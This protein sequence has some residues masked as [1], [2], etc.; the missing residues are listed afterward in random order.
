MLNTP[1][2]SVGDAPPDKGKIG[3]LNALTYPAM[4]PWAIYDLVEFRLTPIVA[5]KFLK[6]QVT[7][8]VFGW[9]EDGSATTAMRF[10]IKGSEVG[11]KVSV[12]GGW[13]NIIQWQVRV[14]WSAG[15]GGTRQDFPFLIDDVV[16]TFRCGYPVLDGLLIFTHIYIEDYR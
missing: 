8:E 5:A 2:T 4:S 12:P 15:T 10:N 9:R 1:G 13:K 6:E 11:Y 14:W 7:V 3:T 16:S